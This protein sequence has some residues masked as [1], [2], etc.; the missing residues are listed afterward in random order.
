MNEIEE[1][2]EKALAKVNVK[3]SLFDLAMRVVIAETIA[4]IREEGDERLKPLSDV[5]LERLWREW[6]R[7][8]SSASFLTPSPGGVEAFVV[9]A[10]TA[11]YQF[12]LNKPKDIDSCTCSFCGRIRSSRDCQQSHP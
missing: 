9:W 2:M 7:L 4:M 10:T 6:S 5:A 3:D 1:E 12:H 11:P 8:S